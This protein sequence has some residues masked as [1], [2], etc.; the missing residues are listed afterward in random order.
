MAAAPAK[1]VEHHTTV[2]D[3]WYRAVED[4]RKKWEGRRRT[5]KT[6]SYKTGDV[7]LIGHHTDSTK[8]LLRRTV[9]IVK[10]YETFRDALQDLGVEEVLPAAYG[11]FRT[12]DEGCRI[13]EQYVS[14]ATQRADGVL[15][16][17]LL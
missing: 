8:P 11:V 5:A 3:E 14:L 2:G 1:I 9:G 16:I 13:Y 6:L 4:R 10:T 17:E 7:L 12:V 15:M